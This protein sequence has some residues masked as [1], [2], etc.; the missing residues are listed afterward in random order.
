M[1]LRDAI[2]KAGGYERNC[3]QCG[4]PN[5]NI[6]SVFC[7]R[8]CAEKSREELARKDESFYEDKP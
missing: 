3:L 4:E 2:F 6:K 7:S 1:N 8:E 5:P